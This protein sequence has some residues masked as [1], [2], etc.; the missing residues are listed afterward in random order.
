MSSIWFGKC[1]LRGRLRT[2]NTKTC[3]KGSNWFDLSFLQATTLC[4]AWKSDSQD[5]SPH[6]CSTY[7]Y[8]LLYSWSCHGWAFLFLRMSFQ[9]ESSFLSPCVWSSSTLSITLRKYLFYCSLLRKVFLRQWSGLR[10]AYNVGGCIELYLK[11]NRWRIEIVFLFL[12][13]FLLSRKNAGLVS[14]T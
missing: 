8:P 10:E 11:K 1:C 6:I 5:M 13:K 14:W 2:S 4:M 7:T 3:K 12:L 9:P